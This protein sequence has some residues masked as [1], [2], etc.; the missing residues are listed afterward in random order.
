MQPNDLTDFDRLPLA[1]RHSLD[2][3]CTAFESEWQSGQPPSIETHLE[4]LSGPGRSVLLGELLRL[5]L[6][7]R[8]RLGE[9]P[10]LAGYLLRFGELSQVVCTVFGANPPSL[11]DEETTPPR[12]RPGALPQR[13]GVALPAVSG[14]VVEGELGRGG[15][16]VVL[17]ARDPELRRPLAIKM[18]LEAHQGRAELV[19]RFREEARLTGQLQHPGVPP[20]MELGELP[21]GR[22]FFAMKLIEGRTLADLLRSAGA[23]PAPCAPHDLPRFLRYFETVCQTV[24]YAHSRGVIHRDL[25]PQNVMVGAFGEVQVMDWGL[26]KVLGEHSSLARRASKGDRPALARRAHSDTEPGQVIGTLAYMAPEQA[27]G[28]VEELD[29]RA[30]VFGLGAI[31]CVILT[32]EPPFRESAHPDGLTRLP[33]DLSD[34][35]ARLDGCGADAELVRLA[36][37]CLAPLREHRPA[38]GA[39]V[40]QSVGQYLAGVQQRLRQAEMGQARAEAR[41][42]GERKRRRLMVALAA[43]VLLLVLAGGSGVWMVQ[44]QQQRRSSAEQD[45]L[46]AVQQQRGPLDAAWQAHDLAKLKEVLAAADRALAIASRGD[47]SAT[48]Q[49]QAVAFQREAE[50]RLKR[51]ARNNALRQALLDVSGLAEAVPG[52]EGAGG[53]LARAQKS[54]DEQYLDAFQRW[55]LDVN[56]LEDEEIVQ[57]LQREPDI[58]VGDVVAALDQWMLHFRRHGAASRWRRLL[59]LAERLDRSERLRQLRAL[60]VGD[61]PRVESVVGLLGAPLPWPALGDLGRDHFRRRQQLRTLREQF[62]AQSAP[63]LTVLLLAQVGEDLGEVASAEDVLRRALAVRPDE[64]LLLAALGQLLERQGGAKLPEAIGCYRAIRLRHRN[65]GVALAAALIKAERKPEAEAVIRDLVRQEPGNPGMHLNLGIVLLYQNKREEA[66]A[67]FRKAISLQPDLA[68]AHGNLALILYDQN[69]RAEAETAFR[70]A[71]LHKP[72]HSLGHYNLGILLQHQKKLAEAEAAYRKAIRIKP[73]YA[74][75]HFNLGLVLQDQKRLA[76]AEAAFR[77]AISFQPDL[78][79]AH[80]SLGVILLSQNRLSE[81]ETAFRKAISLQPDHPAAHNNLGILLHLQKK[82]KEAETAFRK[83]ISLQPA[84]AGAH[85]GLGVVLQHQKRLKEAETAFR[86]AIHIKPDDAPT[87][88][89]LGRVLG[90]QARFKEAATA[91]KKASDLLDD[92]DPRRQQVQQMLHYYQRLVSLEA[93]LPAILKGTDKPASVAEQLE[94][95]RLCL[96]REHSAASVRLYRAAFADPKLAQAVPLA[97]RYDAA[98]AAA[99]AGCGQGKDA[100]SLDDTQRAGLRQQAHDWLR[101][102]LSGVSKVLDKADARTKAM[103]AE[104]IQHWRSDTD[105]AGVRDKANLAKLPEAERMAWRKLWEDVAALQR[106][107]AA[108]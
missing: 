63:V 28:E 5:D 46:E 7:Y 50:Q 88:F 82:F 98:C 65:L 8:K 96:L 4:R 54:V 40:A 11:A 75:A 84:F 25:K 15:M 59:R 6:D 67:A 23:S 58:V 107:A 49:A 2:R 31:L 90:Q 69:K 77:K 68:A 1:I 57:R 17:R 26:A 76:E 64:V 60:L 55:G 37:E 56:R 24:G 105:L 44:R 43:S 32:G 94:L 71:I 99:L 16:G 38:N 14:Y 42:A 103:I 45:V 18:L 51:A 35:F 20:V 83:T 21:D 19:H 47:A 48:V 61:S 22:P 78:A 34:A 13:G 87:H 85:G 80:G 89:N 91:L 108:R 27:C 81:A 74:P 70:K 97:A 41:A 66:E 3:I 9:T 33:G 92:S 10:D 12:A 72:D 100:D 79:E 101:A 102:N 62:R 29:E 73:D 53:R 104:R 39:A 95:A 52:K 36:R 30:D 106:R 86:K 93:R